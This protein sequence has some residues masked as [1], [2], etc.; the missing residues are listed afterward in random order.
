MGWFDEQ[1][2]LRK[3]KDEEVFSNSFLDIAGAVLGEQF[4]QALN[5]SEM[6]QSAVDE[7]LKF[8]HIKPGEYVVPENVRDFDE[9]LE[10][11]LRPYGIMRRRV[12]L[13]KDWYKCAVSPMLATLKDDESVMVALLPRKFSG[14]SIVDVK[15][16]SRKPVTASVAANI[17]TEAMCFYKPFP[18]RS[19]TVTDIFKFMASTYSVSDIVLLLVASLA[20]TLASMLM[21]W[22][23]NILFS[24]VVE[25]KEV[26]VLLAMF[27]FM[28]CATVSM[29]LF[30]SVKSLAKQRLT[31]KQDVAVNA[32][33]MS[34]II[35]LPP[36]FFKDYSSGELTQRS[37]YMNSLCET[38]MECIG[39]SG[40]S[41]LFSLAYIYQI[42]I[43]ARS[44]VLPAICVVAATTVVSVITVFVQQKIMKERM[45]V[46]TKEFGMSYAMISGI[47]KIKLAGAEKRAFARWAKVYA[48]E[49]KLLY[50]P[51]MLIKINSVI[52]LAITLIGEIVIYY[53][54][55]RDAI[56]VAD[57]YAFTGAYAMLSAAFSGLVNI[58]LN[59]AVIK[60]TLEM[61]KPIMDAEPEM[62]HGKKIVEKLQGGI[63]LNNVSFRYT[64]STPM[65]IDNLSLKIRPGQYVAIVGS[66]GCGK[67][68]LMRLM[69]GFEKPMKGAIYYD[70]KDINSL[71]LKS[72]RSKIGSVMQD[73][74]LFLGDIYSNIVISA[75]QL[76][77][78]DAWAAADI[79]GMREDIEAMPMGMHTLISEG[80]GGISGGQRQRLMIARAVAPSPR[81]LM[82]DEATSALDN[83]TQ[84]K[85]S[86]AIDSMK[87][88][89]IVIAHR[90]STIK[91]SDR[92]IV[93]DKGKIVEDGTYD[94][95]LQ[96]NGV[97]ADLV[98][99][100]RLDV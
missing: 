34:R 21:P 25:S 77:L 76:S 82:F 10:Y 42:F 45:N 11:S 78:D 56:S 17:N 95:L 14:Y 31:T 67:S 55:G 44:L 73:G 63:E 29:Q 62:A 74:K 96:I 90:L 12:V 58:A 88:T 9:G 49:S 43:Y 64:D 60:P 30:S 50:N 47:Q 26:S 3:L 91:N 6:A 22:L 72:L 33:V 40:L 87:C 75:P 53:F 83:I 93:L 18:L 84:K 19:I 65:V 70:G 27:I 97:F 79:A 23:N 4:A 85:V 99:R 32:A 51:P 24:S 36:R 89:R 5:D 37:Q 35:S 8:Y 20:V 57:F 59:I 81:I 80:S 38:I 46:S 1:I 86:E 48:K 61:V 16:G 94:E 13:S 2:K 69:L 54:A 39:E 15:T 28:T 71:D 100:Q 98:K 41:A 66:T 52:G 7:I 68:T 92:I